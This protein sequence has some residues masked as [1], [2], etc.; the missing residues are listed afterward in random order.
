MPILQLSETED[1][2]SVVYNIHVSQDI[3][4]RVTLN[5]DLKLASI[6]LEKEKMKMDAVMAYDMSSNNTTLEG[7]AQCDIESEDVDLNNSCSESVVIEAGSSFHSDATNHVQEHKKWSHAATEQLISLVGDHDEHFQMSMKQ[8]AWKKICEKINKRQNTHFTYQQVDI[9]FKGLKRTYNEVRKHNDTSGNS[10]KNWIFFDQMHDLLFKKP[11]IHPPVICSSS[12]G[13]KVQ[14]ITDN[15]GNKSEENK[16]PHCDKNE[17]F[18]GNMN[19]GRYKPRFGVQKSQ[20]AVRHKKKW[21][22]LTNI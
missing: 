21:I 9:K 3:F 4:N 13:L 2:K 1:D 10:N 8:V 12:K 22:E 18:V 17:K 20:Q 6:L 11:E 5:N 14:N 19:K 7:T 16:E 15:V